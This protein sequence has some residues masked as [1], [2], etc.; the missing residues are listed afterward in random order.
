MLVA[1]ELRLRYRWLPYTA[2]GVTVSAIAIAQLYLG[3]VALSAL[4]AG[5]FVSFIWVVLLGSAYGSHSHDARQLRLLP[6]LALALFLVA[7]SFQ[8]TLFDGPGAL[9]KH[10]VSAPRLMQSDHWRRGG[11]Q[12]LPAERVDFKG[13]ATEPMTVQWVGALARL[14]AALL[15]QGWQEPEPLTFWSAL[16][17]LESDASLA[18]LPLLPRANDGQHEALLLV[19][20]DAEAQRQLVLRLWQSDRGIISGSSAEPAAMG[21]V[22][23]L[24]FGTLSHQ[25]LAR[26]LSQFSVLR[27]EADFAAALESFRPFV[28]AFSSQLVH[29]QQSAP[30]RGARAAAAWHGAV[31]LLS[32]PD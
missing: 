4:L 6:P 23:P 11:W 15:S 9:P 28:T 10:E 14:K 29:R 19:Y 30:E 26:P 1:R 21:A 12:A 31:L 32:R 17:W 18:D 25:R 22:S 27:N 2:A 16:R 13:A 8:A 24:W 3:G 20:R 5:L 7:T